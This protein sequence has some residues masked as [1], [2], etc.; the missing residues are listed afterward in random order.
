MKLQPPD[1]SPEQNSASPLRSVLVLFA[2]F[3]VINGTLLFFWLS[4][5]Q[6]E[7]D[8]T[9]SSRNNTMEVEQVDGRE[10]ILIAET[11]PPAEDVAKRSVA[12]NSLQA[13]LHMQARGKSMSVEVWADKEYTFVLE[14]V[15][16]GEADLAEKRFPEAALAYEQ[17]TSLLAQVLDDKQ[18]KVEQ[19]LLEGE[20]LLQEGKGKD[21]KDAFSRVLAAAP[22]NKKAIEGVER[23][24]VAET[25]V[26]LVRQ[27]ELLFLEKAWVEAKGK[28]RQ[29]VALD[30]HNIQ[31]QSGLVN[32][33][34]VIEEQ[35]LQEAMG[36]F[37]GALGN[38]EYGKAEK[39]L[40]AAR[41][42]KPGSQAVQNAGLQLARAQKAARIQRLEQRL[43]SAMA[44]EQWQQASEL[45]QKILSADKRAG[46]AVQHQD[47]V[48]RRKQ[49]D[50]R[51]EK[52]LS[53]PLRLQ[54]DKA[55]AEAVSL[56]NY[57][58]TIEDPGPRLTG[59][60]QALD[61]LM[62]RMRQRVRV[63]LVS[64]NLSDIIVYKVGNLGRFR[65]KELQLYPGAYTVVGR[66]AGYRDVRK[67]LSV[68]VQDSSLP[69]LAI[70]CEE[71]I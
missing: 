66:R 2:V 22:G 36:D 4:H 42:V 39:A 18:L 14:A 33:D 41:K 29:A 68:P 46:I 56:L 60:Q 43:Q 9:P 65:E 31:A 3:I 67:Q 64:D 63:H 71:P 26:D 11:V 45:I 49:L 34:R 50:Q 48:E 44:Q 58:Q 25:V 38:H 12:E 1:T 7:D 19:L 70:R 8:L 59:Q 32:V 47:K 17:A 37:F 20:G 15:T 13:W 21:A 6:P 24:A 57:A 51:L 62:I 28:F 53:M 61:S 69:V 54:D 27:A 5:M 30:S 10:K 23:A 52:I 55:F 40:A 35:S 16:K